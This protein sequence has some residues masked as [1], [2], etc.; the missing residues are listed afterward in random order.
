MNPTSKFSSP[1]ISVNQTF[2]VSC[3]LGAQARLVTQRVPASPVLSPRCSRDAQGALTVARRCWFKDGKVKSAPGFISLESVYSS[4][5]EDY[6]NLSESVW[7]CV[8]SLRGKKTFSFKSAWA[9]FH[10]ANDMSCFELCMCRHHWRLLPEQLYGRTGHLRV[11][12]W[13]AERI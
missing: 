2:M 7:I 13:K 10:N 4:S 11:E 9:T 6:T 12:H 8:E 5:D 3:A 1:W